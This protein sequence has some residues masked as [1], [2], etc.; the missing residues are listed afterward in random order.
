MNLL[1][2]W[3]NSSRHSP[4]NKPLEATED[5]LLQHSTKAFSFILLWKAMRAK[6]EEKSF[7]EK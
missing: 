4:S 3:R 7:G 5:H 2:I 1:S 6:E